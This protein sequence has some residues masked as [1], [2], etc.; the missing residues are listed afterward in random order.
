MDFNEY[1]K[2]THKTVKNPDNPRYIEYLMLGLVGEAGEIA[3]KYKKVIRDDEGVLSEEKRADL[4]SEIGDVL[5]YAAQLS[6]ILG[7]EFNDIA[8][9]NIDKLASRL[10]RGKISGSGDNR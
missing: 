9:Y 6:A 7:Y 8:Q 5:W 4:K 10:E 1:Q 3:N 2:T